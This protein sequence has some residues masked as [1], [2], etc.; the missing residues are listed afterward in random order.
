LTGGLLKPHEVYTDL[1]NPLPS[2]A[3]G[4][5]GSGQLVGCGMSDEEDVLQTS[6]VNMAAARYL[7]LTINMLYFEGV[8][9][10]AMRENNLTTS[11]EFMGTLD[12]LLYPDEFPALKNE[13]ESYQ[14]KAYVELGDYESQELDEC[15]LNPVI[16]STDDLVAQEEN[17]YDQHTYSNVSQQSESP[18][19]VPE[20]VA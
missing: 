7:K 16:I 8:V 15:Y 19:S 2:E 18:S 6:D 17:Q 12:E 1:L 4:M 13:I 11:T 9:L 20:S 14:N 10:A 5:T 3:V